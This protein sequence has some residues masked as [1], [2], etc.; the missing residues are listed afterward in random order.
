MPG[1][2]YLLIRCLFHNLISDNQMLQNVLWTSLRVSA[3]MTSKL[4]AYR[5]C[6]HRDYWKKQHQICQ[7]GP[8]MFLALLLGAVLFSMHSTCRYYVE[9]SLFFC[10][11]ITSVLSVSIL[12]PHLPLHCSL[13]EWCRTVIWPGSKYSFF[14]VQ[15]FH[16]YR[17]ISSFFGWWQRAFWG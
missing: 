3:G 6:C 10:I 7:N 2:F 16:L 5:F 12:C 9:R 15:K 1:M 13:C 11:G 17:G 14:Y 4:P 8:I